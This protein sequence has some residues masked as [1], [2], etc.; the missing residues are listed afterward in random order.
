LEAGV[1]D[2]LDTILAVKRKEIAEAKETAPLDT[3]RAQAATMPP[4]RDFV[5]AMRAKIAA[6]Q[7]AIIAEIKKASPSRGVI[8][9]DF[10]PAEIA[11]AYAEAGAAC[12]SILTDREFFQGAPEY[13]IGRAHV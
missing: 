5:G 1:S 4:A 2:I 12:L 8:R 11:Q 3:V 7:P 9:A 6:G 13:Q 10:H